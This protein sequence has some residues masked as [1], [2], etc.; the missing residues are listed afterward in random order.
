MLTSASAVADSDAEKRRA[1]AC[2]GVSAW[3]VNRQEALC[4]LL[5]SVLRNIAVHSRLRAL[6]TGLCRGRNTEGQCGVDNKPVLLEPAVLQT[7]ETAD[8]QTVLA[9]KQHS[10]AVLRSGEVC[11]WGSG[12]AGKLGHGSSD[13]LSEPTRYQYQHAHAD[14]CSYI[15]NSELWW[16]SRQ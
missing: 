10:A 6:H 7:L 3:Q 1:S 2:Q 15:R 12:K 9:G 11:T 5:V 8:V 14:Q 13:D 16:T 4:A